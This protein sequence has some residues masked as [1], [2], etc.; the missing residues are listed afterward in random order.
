[1]DAFLGEIRPVGFNYA[2]ANWAL[3]QGQL[4]PISQ[5]SA[6]FSLLGTMYGGDGKTTF[7]LP[8]LCGRAAVCAGQGAGL[9]NYVPGMTLGSENET[10]QLSQLPAHTHA[11]AGTVQASS[12]AGASTQPS[13]NYFAS[14]GLDQF[15]EEPGTSKMAPGAIGGASTPAGDGQPHP[16]MMPYL[17]VNFAICLNG[18]YP[19]RP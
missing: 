18:I 17:A 7:A 4:L 10:L 9:T 16:N 14:N 11:F 13:G 2:P 8:N 3:C 15:S 5:Y 12:A 19:Q 6:L 1:M